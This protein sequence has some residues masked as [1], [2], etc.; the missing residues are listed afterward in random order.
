MTDGLTERI[1]ALVAPHIDAIG[2]TLY[3]VEHSGGVLR[4]VVDRAQPVDLDELAVLTRAIS[5][6]LD[7]QDPIAGRYTL[8]VTSPGLERRLRT[9]A[10]FAAA[11]GEQVKL[12]LHAGV[13]GDRRVDGELREVDGDALVVVSSKGVE[14]RVPL[15]SVAQARTVFI[16]GPAPRPTGPAPRRSRP[17]PSEREK[18]A[19]S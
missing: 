10:H 3:D 2:A 16:W 5:Q 18:K 9:P 11:V 4:V 14:Q 17:S 15:D 12:K 6:L 19:A 7:E 13:E 8:E 1:G